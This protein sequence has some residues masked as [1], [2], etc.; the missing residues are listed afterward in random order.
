M[1]NDPCSDFAQSTPL[2]ASFL[3]SCI[4]FLHQRYLQK[5]S[6][7][8]WAFEGQNPEGIDQF[9]SNEGKLKIADMRV[10]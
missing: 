3:A 8:L 7:V 1:E 2:L 9:C 6:P 10:G 5:T 4:L